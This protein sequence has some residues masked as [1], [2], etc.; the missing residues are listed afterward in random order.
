MKRFAGKVK[1]LKRGGDSKCEKDRTVLI[2]V[3]YNIF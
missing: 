1:K 2:N 3:M